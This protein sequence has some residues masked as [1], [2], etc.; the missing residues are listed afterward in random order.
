MH[1]I[2]TAY[3]PSNGMRFESTGKGLDGV[4]KID[5]LALSPRRTRL[6]LDMKIS[7][8]TVAATILLQSLRFARRNIDRR[9]KSKLAEFARDLEMGRRRSV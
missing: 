8:N 1:V 6:R 3:E 4:V 7:A 5:L 2:L 9:F